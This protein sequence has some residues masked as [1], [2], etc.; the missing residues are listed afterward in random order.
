L[1]ATSWVTIAPGIRCRKHP[2]RKHGARL[3]RYYTVRFSVAG[4][5]VEE[6]L[7]WA[8]EGWTMA[9]AQEKLGELR[10]AGRTGEGHATLREA[11][12]A[13][14]QAKREKAEAEAAS[15]QR[16]RSIRDLW[17]R[18]GKEVVAIE[19]KART[20]AEK[21]RLWERRIGPAIGHLKI[22]D[23][24]EQ[25]AGTVV[26]APLRL[27]AKGKVLGGKAEAGNLYRL[28]HHMFDRALRWGLRAKEVG[29]PLE[30][31]TEPKVNRR[32]RLLTGGEI[33]RWTRPIAT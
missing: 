3:D 13:N 24:T 1:S 28:L 16:Q 31:V 17:D 23:V 8:S 6:A 26:R 30:G 7:G 9:K 12:E 14:R 15:E 27:D 18:Y 29:N 5:Q 25:D 2:T 4:K 20:A 33:G 10:K 19:N 11:A 22:N 21:T 32:E